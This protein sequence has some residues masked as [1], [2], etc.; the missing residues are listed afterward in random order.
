MPGT[1]VWGELFGRK[2]PAMREL[3]DPLG[4]LLHA[5]ARNSGARHLTFKWK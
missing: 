5:M 2:K 1:S 4:L 3:H